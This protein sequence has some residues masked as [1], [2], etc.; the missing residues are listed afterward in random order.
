MRD[1]IQMLHTGLLPV[2]AVADDEIAHIGEGD[3]W[4]VVRDD[5][6]GAENAVVG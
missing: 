4:L 3:G 2:A 1:S 6:A 5:V